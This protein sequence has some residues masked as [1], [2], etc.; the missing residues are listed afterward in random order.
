MKKIKSLL[1]LTN[2]MKKHGISK[3]NQEFIE[4]PKSLE[5]F[6]VS[7]ERHEKYGDHQKKWK[8]YSA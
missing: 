1:F 4:K 6:I 8:F 2:T 5:F 3:R 7:N